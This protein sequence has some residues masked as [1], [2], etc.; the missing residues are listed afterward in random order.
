[1][2]LGGTGPGRLG[3]LGD[4]EALLVALAIL[5]ATAHRWG[6]WLAGFF[7][8]PGLFNSII[9]LGTGHEANFPNRSIPR[10]E[11]IGLLAFCLLFLILTYPMALSNRALK[12][13][14]RICLVGAAV[15]FW[16]G[17]ITQQGLYSWMWLAGCLSL[18]FTVRL[19][20]GAKRHRYRSSDPGSLRD[21]KPPA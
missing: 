4:L 6:R 3:V 17:G 11:G 2:G 15:S 1:M 10:I 13:T 7:G 5:F 16:V 9:A 21:Q 14:D 20:Y 19:R 12:T 8:L 18:L